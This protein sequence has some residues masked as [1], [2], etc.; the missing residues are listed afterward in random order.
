MENKPFICEIDMKRVCYNKE[1]NELTLDELRRD[2]EVM[3]QDY[4]AVDRF[5]ADLSVELNKLTERD[6][7]I[8]RKLNK[9]NRLTI[10]ATAM[11]SLAT[12]D[13]VAKAQKYLAKAEK[14]YREIKE[15]LRRTKI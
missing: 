15:M 8:D 6:V 14:E 1:L 12:I 9:I 10:A 5:A 13:K 11:A 2:Y 4:E 7:E 3:R